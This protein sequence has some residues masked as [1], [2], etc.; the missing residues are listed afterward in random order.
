MEIFRHSQNSV[1]E[2]E[3]VA[4]QVEHSSGSQKES[5]ERFGA[6]V[7]RM[8]V[9]Q[10]S[11]NYRNQCYDRLNKKLQIVRTALSSGGEKR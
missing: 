9:H 2:S 7:A 11:R 1:V 8:Q 5:H 4:E 3:A 6:S 10:R